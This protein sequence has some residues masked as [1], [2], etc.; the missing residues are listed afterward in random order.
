MIPT[1]SLAAL[2]PTLTRSTAGPNVRAKGDF[3]GSFAQANDDAAAEGAPTPTLPAT[4]PDTILRQDVAA[5]G[6]TLPTVV[7]PDAAP[8]IIPALATLLPEQLAT[9][10]T[11]LRPTQPKAETPVPDVSANPTV[12]ARASATVARPASFAVSPRAGKAKDDAPATPSDDASDATPTDQPAATDPHAIDP[13][14]V[15]T[16]AEMLRVPQPTIPPPLPEGTKTPL[17]EV[18]VAPAASTIDS[19][20]PAGKTV[21][22]AKPLAA[23]EPQIVPSDT[24]QIAPVPRQPRD[25]PI[26]ALAEPTS[27]TSQ[28]K[29]T[30]LTSAAARR[31]PGVVEPSQLVPGQAAPIAPLASTAP[32]AIPP[33]QIAALAAAVPIAPKPMGEQVSISPPPTSGPVADGPPTTDIATIATP[34]WV[35]TDATTPVALALARPEPVQPEPGTVASASQVFGAAIQAATKAREDRDIPDQAALSTPVSAPTST[36]T[37]RTFDAQHA[38]LDMRQERWPHAMIE[39]IEILRDAADATDTR[40]RLIPD[41]LGAIDVSV[42]KD[43]DT[44]HVHFNAEQSATRTLLADAQPRLAELAE[45]RGLKLGQGALQAGADQAG[46]NASSGQQRAQSTAR[47]PAPSTSVTADATEDTRIA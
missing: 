11:P 35:A 31:M 9:S 43:G 23:V 47:A 15:V 2:L 14:V 34:R 1:A 4:A 3:A 29:T 12:A 18:V 13:P 16:L 39:R 24:T 28:F 44:V 36:E 37:I 40:I 20:K 27:P 25:A 33:L 26:A 7:V 10:P 5:T 46:S 45:A 21:A 41:A 22:A 8:V 32:V 17:D 6:N 30:A 38:P 19:A 42:R